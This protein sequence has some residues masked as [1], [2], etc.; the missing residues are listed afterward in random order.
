MRRTYLFVFIVASLV[1]ASLVSAQGTAGGLKLGINLANMHG[2]DVEDFGQ[3]ARMGLCVGG[4]LGFGLGNVVVI[5]PELLYSQKGIAA[6]EG[7]GEAVMKVDYIDIPVAVKLMVPVKGNIQP[8]FSAGPYFAYNINATM[9][10]SNNGSHSEEDLGDE[11]KDMDFGAVL[12]GGLGFKLP[13]GQII[14]DVRYGLGLTSIDES[15]G[16]QADV[17][18]DAF[19]FTLG[20]AF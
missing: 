11:I 1:T 19:S 5:Q 18:N 17:K 3:E 13:K 6:D 20:Y 4:F 9:S 16:E 2:D 12:G 15:D 14:F 10:F 7:I 8:F